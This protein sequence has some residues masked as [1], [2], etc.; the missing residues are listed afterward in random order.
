MLPQRAQ[1]A[2]LMRYAFGYELLSCPR[3]GCKM[4]L[5]AFPARCGRKRS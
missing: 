3:C 1:W 4:K 2:E 5:L